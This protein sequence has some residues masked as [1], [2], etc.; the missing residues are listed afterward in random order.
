MPIDRRA[1]IL[2]VRN[3]DDYRLISIESAAIGQAARPGQ[4]VMVKISDRFSPL[5][6]R[7]LSIHD[8]SDRGIDL[9]FQ[10]AGRGTEILAQ[11]RPGETMDLLGPLGKG[12]TVA[13]NVS[14]K[15]AACIGGGRGIA[16]L[17]YLARSLEAAGAFVTVYYGGRKAT[18]LPL[19]DKFEGAGF[20][21]NCSTDD[22]SRGFTGFVTELFE[23]GLQSET[24]D[25]LF[26]C[27]PDPMMRAVAE[28]VG[29]QGIPAEY[30]LEAV[31]GCGIGACWGCVHRIKSGGAEEWV[32][33]CE[34]GPVFPGD[35]IV[36]TD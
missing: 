35:R 2:D 1:R 7:P 17:F 13:D 32:K 30:S 4:F 20:R 36:W 8:A 12:Y 27:G 18:D 25:R 33:I 28:L 6:R 3:W 24:F 19:L 26:A 31:M 15:R 21:V 34:E 5:L 22:G 10:I 23:A 9:F 29:P 14:G 16:P 11:K